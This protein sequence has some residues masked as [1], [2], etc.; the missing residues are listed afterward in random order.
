MHKSQG[1]C[2]PNPSSCCAFGKSTFQRETRVDFEHR[3]SRHMSEAS[4]QASGGSKSRLNSR[5][6]GRS[7][8][9]KSLINKSVKSSMIAF[10]RRQKVCEVKRERKA[11]RCM[12]AQVVMLRIRLL[13]CEEPSTIFISWI[14]LSV[15]CAVALSSKLD[16]QR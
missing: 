12:Q 1:C 3:T 9:G 7:S 2:G 16:T 4:R 14:K 11:L 6:F 15:Y 8:A 10:T 5:A 13:P